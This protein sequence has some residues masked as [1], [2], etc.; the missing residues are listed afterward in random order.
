MTKQKLSHMSNSPTKKLSFLFLICFILFL[1]SCDKTP[2]I[3]CTE[4]E[5]DK[6]LGN[7]N[8]SESCQLTF[9]HGYTFG[10]INPGFGSNNEIVFTNFINSGQNMV[11][12]I[13]CTGDYFRIPNQQ[14]GGSA[15][16][17]EGEGYYYNTG[18]FVQLQFSI[19]IFEFGQSDRCDYIYSK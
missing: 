10:T 7:Y 16:T 18:G 8:V 6:Y 11:A 4:F 14:L 9:G 5:T 19:Q 1:G 15:L 3:T 2:P 12:Y 17:V 13:D